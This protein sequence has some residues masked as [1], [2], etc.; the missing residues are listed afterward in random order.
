MTDSY[1]FLFDKIL[2]M[3]SQNMK[4][5]PFITMKKKCEVNIFDYLEMNALT[6]HL[7]LR[8]LLENLQRHRPN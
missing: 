7:C 2:K 4:V 8:K 6:K 1:F 3:D 5:W